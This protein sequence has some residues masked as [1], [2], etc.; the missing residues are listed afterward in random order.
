[1]AFRC[2]LP[3]GPAVSPVEKA[4]KRGAGCATTP[5]QP[6]V[7]GRAKGQI[8]KHDTVRISCAQWMVTG[9]NGV[10]GKNAQEAVAMATKRGREL[11]A[12]HRLSMVGGRVR[13]TL[14]KPSCVTLG[15]AQSMACGML[16][17]LGVHAAKAVEKAVRP[18]RGS[19]TTRHH[20]LVGPT[21]M[22]QKPRCK[23]AMRDSVQWTAS[24]HLGPVG[25]PALYP[26]EEVPGREPGTAPTQCHSME[27]TNA[28]G[29][30][31]RVT[32]AIVTLVQPTVTGALGVAGGRAAGRA[33]EGR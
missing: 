32:F 30:V 17:S 15:L 29:L 27:E 20:H 11:A 13:G 26:V 10:S 33:V 25:V 18:E 14:W 5:L 21:A 8:Q 31:S 9:Q 4:S 23:S 16:G 12:T 3:G 24:G 19:A 7:G 1:M 22:E 28:R 6:T 2:G